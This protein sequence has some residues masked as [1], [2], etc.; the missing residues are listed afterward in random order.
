MSRKGKADKEP[1]SVADEAEGSGG[2]SASSSTQ[3][4]GYSSGEDTDDEVDRRRVVRKLP[5]VSTKARGTIRYFSMKS[6]AEPRGVLP[7]LFTPRTG[8][9]LRGNA[10]RPLRSFHNP[11][12]D[13]Y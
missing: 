12:L 3:D 4:G 2:P 8:L 11:Q 9:L 13:G 5:Q 10:R 6:R 7:H 1:D